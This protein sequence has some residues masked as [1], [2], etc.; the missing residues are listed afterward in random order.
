MTYFSTTNYTNF[1]ELKNPM[2]LAFFDKHVM[3]SGNPSQ[4]PAVPP[5]NF[6]K[7]VP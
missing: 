6:Y 7:R 2:Y 4:L 5:K 1:H 3:I